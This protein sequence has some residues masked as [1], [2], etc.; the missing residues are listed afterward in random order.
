MGRMGSPLLRSGLHLA[1]FNTWRNGVPLGD[2]KPA[3]GY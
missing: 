3:T 2:E 1:G